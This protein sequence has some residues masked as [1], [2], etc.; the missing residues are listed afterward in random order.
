MHN[1]SLKKSCEVGFLFKFTLRLEAKNNKTTNKNNKKPTWQPW[2]E[3]L[4]A[5]F[6]SYYK[7]CF[8]IA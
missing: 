4:V 8:I 6:K 2:F 3:A 1:N 7:H 5:S